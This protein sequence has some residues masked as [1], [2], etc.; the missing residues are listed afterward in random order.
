MSARCVG[1]PVSWLRLER[2]HLGDIHGG[3][4][5]RIAEHLATCAVC[6]ACLSRIEQDAAAPLPSLSLAA[7]PVPRRGARVPLFAR[8]AVVVG[9]VAAA[10][11]GILAVH[12]PGH[13]ADERR[14]SASASR[15]KGGGAVAFS[16]VRDDA[17]RID[18]RE[19]VYRESDRFKA[20]V[21]CP[22]T[23]SG[24]FDLVVYDDGG[25]SFPLEAT[26]LACGNDVPLP[27]AFRLTGETAKTVCVVWSEEGQGGR[28]PEEIGGHDRAE[29]ARGEGAL[30]ERSSCKRLSPAPRLL[31]R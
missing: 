6:A 20:M 12:G 22:P 19:G 13:R 18:G 16:L 31:P 7:T 15:A 3:E 28:T 17:E 29:V 27:G 23:M 1:E 26:L 30:G 2:Y 10:V 11:G 5:T 25:A 24:M 14:S 8:A 4:R 9:T 21:T